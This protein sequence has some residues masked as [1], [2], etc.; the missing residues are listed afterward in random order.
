MKIARVRIKNILGIEELEFAPGK[1]FTEIVGPNGAGKTTVLE[2]IKSVF[3][4]GHDATLLRDGA[5]QGEV[6]LELDDGAEIKKTVRP[7]TS[8]TVV[9]RDNRALPRPMELIKS[10][11]DQWSNNPVQFLT[12][13]PED[14]VTL[15]LQSVPLKV[16]APYLEQI[17]GVK[18]PDPNLHAYHV[19]EYVHDT[20]FDDRTDTNR[21]IDEKE[22]TIRQLRQAMPDAPAGVVGGEEELEARLRELD[23][24]KNSDLDAVHQ[25]LSE[26][27]KAIEAQIATDSADFDQRIL[28]LQREIESL[29]SQKVDAIAALR[30][31]V[32][33]VSARATAK[34][35][36]ISEQ[37]RASR[38]PIDAQL[39][40]LRNNREA[41]VKRKLTLENIETMEQELKQL[42]QDTEQQTRA[43]E[44]IKQY[45]SDVLRKLPVQNVEVRNG[46]IY[47][48]NVVFDRLNTQQR[49]DIA[50]EIAKLRAGELGIVCVDGIEAMDPHQ[51][52]IFRQK[53]SESG[54]QFVVSRVTGGAFD[55]K[56]DDPF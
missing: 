9:K 8:D 52:E 39:T 16:D 46:Q 56:T 20:V 37:H 18:I 26:F 42:R 34:R 53:C 23:A 27:S 24:Q 22:K 45:K 21:A 30:M 28:T 44:A 47:K 7:H 12:A 48:N 55:I 5:K 43:L 17:S 50:V 19:I 25:K 36:E 41:A 40:I 14:R 31:R 15:F 2:A 13:K 10:L 1:G 6:V 33:N 29:R 32:T 38:E 54:L 35:E 4:G 11:V 3:K 49:V 51:F